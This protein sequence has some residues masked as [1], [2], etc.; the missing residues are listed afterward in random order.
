MGFVYMGAL[1]FHIHGRQ[2]IHGQAAVKDCVPSLPVFGAFCCVPRTSLTGPS[3]LLVDTFF[4]FVYVLQR[5]MHLV[6]WVGFRCFD[7][8]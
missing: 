3:I 4:P 2:H 6:G 8:C 7:A 5:D 1:F